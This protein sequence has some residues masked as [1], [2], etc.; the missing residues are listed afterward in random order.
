MNATRAAAAT[1][2]TTLRIEDVDVGAG[3]GSY[4]ATWGRQ[5]L[6]VVLVRIDRYLVTSCK[7]LLEWLPLL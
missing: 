4:V 6:L 5:A 3:G 7:P 2:A 1:T